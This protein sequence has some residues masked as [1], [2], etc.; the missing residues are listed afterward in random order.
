MPLV[1]NLVNPYVLNLSMTS[2]L[3]QTSNHAQWQIACLEIQK[4]ISDYITK[5]EADSNAIKQWP[6]AT[7]QNSNFS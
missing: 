5:C 2:V 1:I 4:V 7:V 6:V 3:G